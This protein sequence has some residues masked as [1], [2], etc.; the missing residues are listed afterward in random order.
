[1]G[2][3][4]LLP[5]E[6]AG[7]QQQARAHLPPHDVGPLVEQQRQVAVA[8]RPLGHELADDRLGR[9]P[10]HH[11]L[12]ELLAAGVGDHR[13][14][15][16]R[17]TAPRS[18]QDARDRR[19]AGVPVHRRGQAARPHPHRP[20][21]GRR[22]RRRRARAAAGAAAPASAPHRQ[23]PGPLRMAEPARAA[24]LEGL[25]LH[26]ADDLDAK[27]NQAGALVAAVDAG[28]TSYDRSFGR[29]FFRHLPDSQPGPAADQ[30]AGEHSDEPPDDALAVANRLFAPFDG[31]QA[32]NREGGQA[33][34]GERRQAGKG[35]ARQQGG[36]GAAD[37]R[38]SPAAAPERSARPALDPE[39]PPDPATLDLFG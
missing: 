4:P 24:R 20:P 11:R 27:M 3:V 17:R 7:A 29:D 23:P 12:L 30:P 31:P 5:Q 14:G 37:S 33:G 21:N 25:V 39:P 6:L 16:G 38:I 9:R 28:W 1:M 13:P 32:G 19:S 34:N 36:G 8:R 18:R 2:G 26:Y 35:E 15:G 10:H 22:R